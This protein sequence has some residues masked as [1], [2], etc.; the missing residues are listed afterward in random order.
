MATAEIPAPAANRTP[1]E[2]EQFAAANPSADRLQDILAELKN[3]LIEL[4]HRPQTAPVDVGPLVQALQ[5]GFERSAEQAAQTSTAVASLGEHMT[6]FGRNIEGGV[7]KTINTLAQQ[8]AMQQAVAPATP[9]VVERSTSQAAVLGAVALAVI[10]WSILFWIKTGS[11]QLALGT[12]VGAN[13]IACCLLL[14]RRDR[15]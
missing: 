15:S 10:G 12:L 2:E 13:A 14:A 11:P 8:P 5:S 7:T 9:R 3:A 6:Q 1:S 4:T